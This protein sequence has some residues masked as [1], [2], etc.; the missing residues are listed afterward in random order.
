MPNGLRHLCQILLSMGLVL[1][2]PS[3][4]GQ[5]PHLMY[6]IGIFPFVDPALID[7]QFGALVIQ[8]GELLERPVQLRTRA[9][10]STFSQALAEKQ[11]D[12]ALVQPFDYVDIADRGDYLPL[13]RV[14][15]TLNAILVVPS[16]ST[17]R[18]T[19]ELSGKVLA[20][21][22]ATAAV[23]MLAG[24]MLAHA[25]LRPDENIQLEY[26]RG[27]DDCL[28]ATLKS[29]ADACVTAHIAL[30]IFTKQHQASFRVLEES[31]PLPHVVFVVKSDTPQAEREKLIKLLLRWSTSPA[32]QDPI[33]GAGIHSGLVVARDADYDGIRR[34]RDVGQDD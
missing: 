3:A 28:D 7:S 15:D 5:H 22:P 23:S 32:Q 13:L 29:R 19:G 17:I 14:A 2:A 33:S 1:L 24:S 34:L 21:P 20:L 12:L 11:F 10:F 6:R 4:Q 8:V 18:Q 27:H 31:G 25:G 26:L 9:S 16:N 30:N